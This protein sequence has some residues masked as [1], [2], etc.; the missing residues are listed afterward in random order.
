VLADSALVAS[1]TAPLGGAALPG[2]W[3]ARVDQ[4]QPRN[5]GGGMG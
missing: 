5:W 3:P 1:V 4:V 2:L